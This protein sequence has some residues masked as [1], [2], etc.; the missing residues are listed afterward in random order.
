LK[1]QAIPILVTSDTLLHLYHIQFNEILKR[2]EEEEFFDELIDMSLVMMERAKPTPTATLPQPKPVV[3][4]V[5]PVPEFY[6]RMLALTKM[7]KKGLAQLDALSDEER[8]RLESLENI[9]NK[10]IRISKYELEGEE[11]SESDYAFIRGFGGQLD[12]IITGVEANL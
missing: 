6:G 1:E 8:P 4:Y 5:E 10:L 9:L 2:L 11:L 3:G 12:S 7:T